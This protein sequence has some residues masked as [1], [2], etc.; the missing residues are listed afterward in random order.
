MDSLKI[1]EACGFH[2][3]SDARLCHGCQCILPT[4]RSLSKG[5]RATMLL[6]L[7]GAASLQAAC[8]EM[9][10]VPTGG[11]DLDDDGWYSDVDCDDE[12]PEIHPEAEEIPGD[13]ID[14]NCNDSD[15]D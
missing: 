15:D 5:L 11:I 8:Q 6:G 1:C 12:D 10:G 9:Y 7:V 4:E 13:G 2:N 14:S 3:R